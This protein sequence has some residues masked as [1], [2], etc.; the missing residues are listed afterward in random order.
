MRAPLE[1]RGCL[2][3]FYPSGKVMIGK[4][5]YGKDAATRRVTRLQDGAL[6][7]RVTADTEEEAIATAR[8]EIERAGYAVPEAEA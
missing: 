5:P 2:V 8:V 7:V 6:T 1:W 3:V 4:S